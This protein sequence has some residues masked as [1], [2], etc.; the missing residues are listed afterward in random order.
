MSC[1]IQYYMYNTYINQEAKN[2]NWRNAVL[3]DIIGKL[4]GE[5]V[6]RKCL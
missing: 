5:N 3:F 2:H 6:K 4:R 1:V